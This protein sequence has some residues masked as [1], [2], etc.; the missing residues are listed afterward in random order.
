M[1]GA[2]AAE[3]RWKLTHPPIFHR[4]GRA[5][6]TRFPKVSLYLKPVLGRGVPTE[7]TISA[8]PPSRSCRRDR[9]PRT[10]LAFC[11]S[12]PH[13]THS[14]P[15]PHVQPNLEPAPVVVRRAIEGCIEFLGRGKTMR[16][17]RLRMCK[18][19]RGSEGLAHLTTVTQLS[20]SQGVNARLFRDNH[21]HHDPTSNT[22][23]S[24][25]TFRP[26]GL[27]D[28]LGAYRVRTKHS[29]GSNLLY[30]VLLGMRRGH[31]ARTPN[32]P[33]TQLWLPTA[34]RKA[35]SRCTRENALV[36]CAMVGLD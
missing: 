27:V 13:L 25:R 32:T 24:G 1:T 6:A 7:Y 18:I 36:C 29:V 34:R 26:K 12:E 9:T 15:G 17:V 10:S 20:V 3:P 28:L 33:R 2:P 22:R 11:L 21:R 31:A 30:T 19:E 8:T 16:N 14:C 23:I 5:W 4:G 35:P